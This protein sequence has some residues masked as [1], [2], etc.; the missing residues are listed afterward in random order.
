MNS[1][2][3]DMPEMPKFSAK[4][5]ER[6]RERRFH[7]VKSYVNALRTSATKYCNENDHTE[8]ENIL[9][10]FKSLVYV[11]TQVSCDDTDTTIRDYISASILNFNREFGLKI[12]EIYEV[13]K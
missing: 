10:Y 5:L 3:D 12:A 8:W 7:T 9:H 13:K 2:F 6:L 1:Q 4:Y 11:N